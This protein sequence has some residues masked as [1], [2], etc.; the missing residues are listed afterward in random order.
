MKAKRFFT[1]VCI[2]AMVSM[3]IFGMALSAHAIKE[4]DKRAGVDAADAAQASVAGQMPDAKSKTDKGS[5]LHGAIAINNA[6]Y[7]VDQTITSKDFAGLRNWSARTR[8]Y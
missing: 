6:E 2:T 3:F 7:K 8:G 1:A 5:P 4:I